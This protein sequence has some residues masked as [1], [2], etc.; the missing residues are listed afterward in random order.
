MASTLQDIREAQFTKDEA[1]AWAEDY[2]RERK[3]WPRRRWRVEGSAAG[4]SRLLTEK[5]ALRTKK[6][7]GG[8]VVELICPAKYYP[9][10]CKQQG[11]ECVMKR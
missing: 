9:D 8:E 1:L 10:L 2:Y 3:N 4:N 5:Q 6:V 11:R 7:H